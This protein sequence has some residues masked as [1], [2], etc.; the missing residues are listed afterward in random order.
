[1]FENED[2]GGAPI[3][4]E[5]V[6]REVGGRLGRAALVPIRKEDARILGRRADHWMDM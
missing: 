5:L 3:R 1:M 4:Y 6:S 2:W